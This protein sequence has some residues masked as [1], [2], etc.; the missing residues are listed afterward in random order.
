MF[1]F[2]FNEKIDFFNK[3]KTKRQNDIDFANVNCWKIFEFEFFKYW[4]IDI[5]WLIANK[6]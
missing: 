1:I 3:T 2:L 4:L 6:K 5:Y